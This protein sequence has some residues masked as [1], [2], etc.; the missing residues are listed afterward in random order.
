MKNQTL[1][2]VLPLA[3]SLSLV[4]SLQAA[5]YVSPAQAARAANTD[6]E[7]L[8][9][10]YVT[11]TV[12]PIKQKKIDLKTLNIP[13]EAAL[14][15]PHAIPQAASL[16]AFLSGIADS[17][18]VLYGHMND[19]LMHAGPKGSDTYG[20]VKDY[21]AV[22]SMDAMTLA[23]NDTE[24]QKHKPAPGALPPVTGQAAI[25]R[26]VSLSL[27]AAQKGAIVSLSAH[28]PNFAD[29]VKKGKTNGAY[30]FSGFTS[31][32][33]DGNVVTRIMPGGDLNEAYTAYLNKIAAYGLALQKKGVPVLFRPFH[34]N[35][36]S[37]FWWGAAHCSA[38]EFKNLYRY[39]EEYLRD[40][41]G[42][43]NFLYV[44]SPNG[45]IATDADYLARYPGDAFIDVPG[46]DMYHEKPQKKDNWMENFGK[47]L[48]AV[49]AFAQRH[50]KVTTV[51]EAGILRGKD[52]L[53]LRG[54]QRLDWFTEA[55]N[56]LSSRKY[57]YFSTWSN[58]N[59]HIFDQPYMISKTRGHEMVDGFTRFYNDPRS[60]FAGQLP[61][62]QKI[63]VKTIPAAASYG[64]LLAPSSNAR[65]TAPAAVR[66]KA[67]GAYHGAAFQ[68][69]DADGRIIEKT[70]AVKGAD[71]LYHTDI[72]AEAL[73]RIG[74]TVGNVE[75]L[76]DG[77][78]AD[79]LRVFYNM[80][81]TKAP[82]PLVDDF[83]SYYGDNELLR[84]AYSTNCGPGCSIQASLATGADE[85]SEGTHGLDF[86]YSIVKGGWA[87]IIK[88]MG[89]N[90]GGYNAISFYLR[91]DGKGQRFLIQLNSDGEDFEL[92]LTGLAKTTKP[93]HVILPFSK[94]VGKNGGK[95]HPERLQHFAIYCNTIGDNPVDSHFYLDDI[96]AV[97]QYAPRE[98]V[99]SRGACPFSHSSYFSRPRTKSAMQHMRAIGFTSCTR[100]MSAPAAIAIT[101]EAPVASM[102]SSTGRPSVS[103]MNRLRD[104]T[105]CQARRQIKY[106][107]AVNAMTAVLRKL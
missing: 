90:W 62:W 89:V 72:T 92:N 35:N 11:R 105:L 97:K 68:F 40:V 10:G 60:I 57:P 48:D 56:V 49:Q 107:K 15:D 18:Y 83:E 7:S 38:S 32:V 54:N 52:T 41:K 12:K 22:I 17:D 44:Y 100:T 94:F 86:H 104:S 23:G 71:G 34:E 14:S 74:K 9:D 73:K 51:P 13:K 26:T 5:V 76:L 63:P 33:T 77:K 29:V 64:Y 45:P 85:H 87:G 93:Q 20:M 88:S 2:H 31:V 43:H 3:L 36:G 4:F 46:I 78:T 69:T 1:R 102:R 82:L 66:A 21:P 98:S 101:H 95:F 30:D 59:A 70:P 103:A 84:D 106:S 96:H 28:M 80:P 39:T 8:D 99:D 79:S 75:F 55:L 16:Y 19:L 65:I 27:E 61:A 67:A 53:G 58:F 25:D 50:H 24:Y 37:W 91:P 6:A 42:V 47:T 81:K